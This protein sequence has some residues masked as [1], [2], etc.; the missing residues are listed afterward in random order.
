MKTLR[1]QLS[2]SAQIPCRHFEIHKLNSKGWKQE[3]D[4]TNPKQ[5]RVQIFLE[6]WE[7]RCSC[8]NWRLPGEP[9]ISGLTSFLSLKLHEL[10]LKSSRHIHSQANLGTHLI[11]YR[12]P[13]FL[14][15]GNTSSVS[16]L[17]N[18]LEAKIN[19]VHFTCPL[20][21]T[22]LTPQ[23]FARE[24]A[25]LSFC[26]SFP[27]HFALPCFLTLVLWYEFSCGPFLLN[28]ILNSGSSIP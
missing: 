12:K 3:K 9:Q 22:A 16:G 24:R 20:G 23:D 2:E 28:F 14:G 8:N 7:N 26:S 1:N 21:L 15:K 11:H 13:F 4:W 17:N 19:G 6:I 18:S 27:C 25:V 5:R 10:K